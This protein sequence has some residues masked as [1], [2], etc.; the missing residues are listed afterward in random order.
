MA[1]LLA[2]A[3][4]R[5]GI[6]GSADIDLALSGGGVAAFIVSGLMLARAALRETP[7]S[8]PAPPVPAAAGRPPARQPGPAPVALLPVLRLVAAVVESDGVAGDETA[9]R[10]ALR[11]YVAGACDE[12]AARLA[13][14]ADAPVADALSL[15]GDPHEEASHFAV[16]L[17]DLLLSPGNRTLYRAGRA[18]MT[19]FL[20][21]GDSPGEAFR[22]ALGRR[23]DPRDGRTVKAG[24][25]V[26]AV[27]PLPPGSAAA[28]EAVIGAFGGE[29][30]GRGVGS[31]VATFAR[32]A[33]AVAAA[34]AI[35]DAG[36]PGCALTLL[37]AHTGDTVAGDAVTPRVSA[38]LALARAVPGEAVVTPVLKAAFAA[39]GDPLPCV[40]LEGRGGYL[41]R[42]ADASSGQP[43]VRTR[44]VSPSGPR[45]PPR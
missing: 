34:R 15:L 5:S 27:A 33:D 13:P 8:S 6:S 16:L 14:G 36:G 28:V 7:P 35:R 20:A 3:A 4:G 32:T 40:R 31:L 29:A 42:D 1:S 2:L 39:N 23:P 22:T 30:F 9:M 25:L 41:L 44:P 37:P 12:R 18:D 11:L 19:A 43:L 38:L 26:M 17:D 21:G 10:H 24:R 45:E